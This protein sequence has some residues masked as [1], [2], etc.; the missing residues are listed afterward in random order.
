M[1]LQTAEHPTVQL[2]KYLNVVAQIK[3]L[4]PSQEQ[5]CLALVAAG[6]EQARRLLVES[7]LPR[8]VSWVNPFRSGPLRFDELIELG[9]QALV[10]AAWS[11]AKRGVKALEPVLKAAVKNEVKQACKEAEKA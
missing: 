6:E 11:A 9:N 2:K 3:P 7:Y 10:V 8:V 5:E 1:A 4:A